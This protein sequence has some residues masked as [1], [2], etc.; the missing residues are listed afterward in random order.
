M[1]ALAQAAEA[2]GAL[3]LSVEV[4]EGRVT[5]EGAA[6]AFG[7]EGAARSGLLSDFTERVAPADRRA[8]AVFEREGVGDVRVR[9]I[10]EDGRVRYARLRGRG[11]A[12]RWI[13]LVLP[14]GRAGADARER[15]DA[16]AALTDAVATGAVIAHYQP[17]VALA[18]R[19][20][21]GFEALA[22]WD[23]PGEGVLGPDDFIPLAGD[24]DLLG[25]IGEGVRAA[26]AQ[27]LS[28]W[29]AARG[30]LR[31]LF[32][33]ANADARE[34]AAPG[35][36]ET[37]I[38]TVAA[39]GVPRGA[40]KLEIAETEVM[41]DPEACLATLTR[42]REAGIA[43]VLDDFGTGWSSLA[44]LDRFPFDVIKVDQY[45]VRAARSDEQARRVIE[46]VVSLARNYSNLVVAEGVEDEAA[47]ELV[48]ELGCDY[49]QG[50]MFAGALAPGAAAVAARD[51][52]PG[53]ASAPD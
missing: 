12:G 45:F 4:A 52:L 35:F 36:A 46:S 26:A 14:A 29:R 25:A 40:Y 37:L 48:A 1:S 3:A 47:A 33:S 5:L 31:E 34:I 49:A 9:L 41:R 42:L 53:R 43:L 15:A 2:A 38:E 24:M 17:I 27:D 6:D 32:V 13:G 7:L 28:A 11:E 21:A 20:L 39:S 22:R 44:R 23:R 8:L 16:E 18:D 51:G 19:R 10:S 30:P 50:F